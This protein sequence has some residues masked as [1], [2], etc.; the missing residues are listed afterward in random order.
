MEAG[1][2]MSLRNKNVLITGISGF[3]GSHMA[4]YLL[5]KRV[6][7]FGLVRRRADG[8]IPKNIECLGIERETELLE[9]DIRDI[10]SIA[11]VLD[12]SKPDVIF[13]LASQSFIPRSFS[14]PLE[15]ME[16]NCLGTANLLEAIRI[17]N[18]DPVVVF[19]GSSEEYGLVF[20]SQRDYERALKKYG[21]VFPEPQQI[22]ELPITEFNP[23]RPMSPY[24]VSKAY[25]DFLMRNY[26]TS[27]GIKTVVSRGFNHEGAGRG[28]MFVTSVITQQV[29]KLK[30]GEADKIIIGNINAFRDW[31]HFEDILKGYC[32]MAEYGKHGDVYVQGSQRTNSILSYILLSLECA[33]YSIDKI[34]TVDGTKAVEKPTQ[35]DDSE[36]FGLQFDKT[37]VDKLMLEG[38]LEFQLSDKGIIVDTNRGKI[39]IEFDEQRFRLAEVP[40][41]LSKTEKIQRIG[42][43]V[44]HSL[45]DIINDQL[46]YFME[47]KRL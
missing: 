26:H 33:G 17:K 47:P 21:V 10:S 3:V 44:E 31:S 29:M 19:A 1:E 38:E 18:F 37:K 6:K 4:K 42:F 35:M 15:T 23:L 39:L 5:D 12:H 24:A 22:P 20:A 27:Y 9:G 45:K 14:H 13:H 30:L 7:V 34:E 8:S 40:V 2:T 11:T 41:L 25:C 46:N 36:K 28:I 43:K 32:L 16:T